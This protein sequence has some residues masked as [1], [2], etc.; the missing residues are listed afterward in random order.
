MPVD[1]DLRAPRRTAILEIVGRFKVRSQAD[2]VARLEKR[3]YPVTQSSVSRDLWDLGVVKAGGRYVVLDAEPDDGAAELEAVASFLVDETVAGPN[4]VVVRTAVGAAQ[5]VALSAL[6]VV[7]CRPIR[8]RWIVVFG[9][10]GRSGR[11]AAR[12]RSHGSIHGSAGGRV[13]PPRLP[14]GK[15]RLPI[16]SAF[17]RVPGQRGG[18]AQGG[19]GEALLRDSP[20]R[21]SVMVGGWAPV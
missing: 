15:R 21:R 11:P 6:H 20:L 13:V 10:D 3:G 1:P 4:L 16:Y 19:T 9:R 12:P 7:R 8:L 17:H 18:Q 5:S 14:C 2:L